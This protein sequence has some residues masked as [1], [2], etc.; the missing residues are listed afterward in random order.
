MKEFLFCESIAI[1]DAADGFN[2]VGEFVLTNGV[3]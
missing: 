2:L 1:T 3:N